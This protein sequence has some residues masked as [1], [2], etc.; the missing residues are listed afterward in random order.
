M[1]TKYK[2]MRSV[3]LDVVSWE[4]LAKLDDEVKMSWLMAK[5]TYTE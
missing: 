2:E 4:R 1:K 5:Y 3:N